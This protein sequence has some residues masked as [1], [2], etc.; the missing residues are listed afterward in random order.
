MRKSERIAQLE[1]ELKDTKDRLDFYKSRWYEMLNL[2]TN[3]REKY[4]RVPE[5]IRDFFQP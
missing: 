2:C 5:P 3:W 4:Q 1:K